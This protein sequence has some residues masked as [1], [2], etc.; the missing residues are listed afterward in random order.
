MM[1]SRRCLLAAGAALGA[2]APALV[3]CSQGQ[4]SA[5][6]AQNGGGDQAG[7]AAT[8]PPAGGGG[9]PSARVRYDVASA[10]GQ[11]M[12]AIYA[13]G[14]AAMMARPEGDPLNWEFQWYSHWVKGDLDASG[15][16]AEL[17]RIYG[18]TTSAARTLAQKMWDGCQAHGANEDEDF[19]LPWHRMY[20]FAFENI[21]RAVTGNATFTLPY[22]N[23]TDPSEFALPP[24]FLM[25]ND[26]TFGAL[27][28]P[29]R[30][31]AANAGQPVADENTLNLTILSEETYSANGGDAGF[32]QGL[33]NGLHGAVHVSV[34]N[35]T[36]G[37]GVVPWAANDPIFWLHH[38]NIDRIWASWNAAGHANPTDP[39]FLSKPFPFADPTGKE[40]DYVVSQFLDIGTVGYSYDQ[41]AG[42]VQ[43]QAA[44]Q[45][46]APPAAAPPPVGAA[47]PQVQMRMAARPAASPQPPAQAQ[48]E[49]LMAR[50]PA[51]SPAPAAPVVTHALENVSLG[52]GAMRVQLASSA[53]APDVAARAAA[54]LSAPAPRLLKRTVAAAAPK[55][56]P[57]VGPMVG[58]SAPK[59]KTAAPTAPAPAPP[60][61][62]APAPGQRVFIVISDLSTAIQ[63][64]VL[65]SVYLEAPTKGG[66]TQ[67]YFVGTLN[68]FSAMG[69]GMAMGR[70][71]I[72]FDITELAADLA[73]QGRLPANPVL[74]FVPNGKA[75]AAAQ[76]LIGSVAL[77]RQ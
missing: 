66:G 26:A 9:A 36:D 33:D 56:V 27:Y 39:D 6:N 28:R 63:P 61:V 67:D 1:V 32:C 22:W 4:D 57:M 75:L 21:I 46:S 74:A 73:A 23:Y 77:V 7:S 16:T 15:K 10:Q 62:G 24:Q 49:R 72:S 71:K 37:M 3:A 14:V 65:Y 70:R 48:P 44:P 25:P 60:A 30:N 18:S 50:A 76:P 45:V 20:V 40:V 19:F 51:P 8:T 35:S 12:L 17:S 52:A 13:E 58:M 47:A 38:C 34:G 59:T 11:A 54:P 43:A 5:A 29:D 31:P 53:A 55:P 41:L 42:G 69:P 64:G 68:F 2:V